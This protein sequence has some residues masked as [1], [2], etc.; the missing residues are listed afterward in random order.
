MFGAK[1]DICSA[2]GVSALPP[3][4]DIAEHDRDV[5]FVPITTECSAAYCEGFDGWAGQET[6]KPSAVSL[7][8]GLNARSGSGDLNHLE[9]M[10]TAFVAAPRRIL[11]AAIVMQNDL[12]SELRGSRLIRPTK[13]RS[14]LWTVAS[15]VSPI[16]SLP[17]KR[18]IQR[19]SARARSSSIK[20]AG[21][22][23]RTQAF[24]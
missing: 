6:V 24:S 23:K 18:S 8:S 3:K 9:A 12:L 4:A 17:Q 10:R 22:R 14:R 21:W 16:P 19:A 1:A 13:A 7:K 2:K 11:S 15:A 20:C 5:R